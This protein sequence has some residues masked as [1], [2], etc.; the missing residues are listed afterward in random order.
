MSWWVFFAVWG[1]FG[2]GV[3]V[4]ALARGDSIKSDKSE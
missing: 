1:I 3:M 4:G 2:I